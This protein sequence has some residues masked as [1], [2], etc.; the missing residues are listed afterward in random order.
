MLT[1]ALY[2]GSFD[3]FTNA[4][5]GITKRALTVFDNLVI[6]VAR[7]SGKQALFSVDERVEM[8]R[9]VVAGDKRI[10]VCGFEGLTIEYAKKTGAAAIIRGL[11][12][13]ADFEYELAMANMNRKLVNTIETFF[14]MT[15]EEYFFVSSRNV[16]EVAYYGG[17]ISALVPDVIAE[18]LLEKIATLR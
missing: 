14:L 13:V 17:D 4:H 3:P 12:A 10:K 6:G 15:S 18:R 11:R 7:N 16:K 8:I 9:E 5:Y 2:P 1:T